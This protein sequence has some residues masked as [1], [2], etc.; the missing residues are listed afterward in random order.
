[1]ATPTVVREAV[2]TTASPPPVKPRKRGRNR[3]D[4]IAGYLFLTPWILGF[5][6]LTVGPMAASLYLSFT[7]YNLFTSPQWV[8]FD[9]YVQLLSDPRYHQSVKVTL[10]YVLV[11]VPVKLV[12]ALGVALLLN[13]SRRGQGFYRSA[14]YAPSLLGA[15]VSV[16]IVWRALFSDD[17]IVDRA[18]RLVGLNIGGW[19]GNPDYALWLLI[20]LAVWQFGAPM[21][22]F[23]AG[24][25][26][27]PQ[28]LHEAAAVDGA[29]RWR[30]FISITLPMLSPVI[31]FNLLLETIN[32]FQVFTSA[33]V[34]SSGATGGAGGPAGSTLV[35]T[36]Y[37]YQRGFQDLRM[38]YA[39]AMAWM[40][41]L[42]V[43]LVTVLMFRLARFWVFYGGDDDR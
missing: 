8:G 13:N 12:V 23:L 43:G 10:H 22:I 34:V 39:S 15:S 28:E 7:N 3:R 31:F 6:L 30:R 37:L 29:G 40:L 27:V 9:N 32:A 33:F 36:I 24:L 4:Q 25:K 19:I 21:V 16:A 5:V 26:Q 38:G 18:L 11:S 42:V 14:F 20:L 1:M 17:A 41:L 35:Y 2:E